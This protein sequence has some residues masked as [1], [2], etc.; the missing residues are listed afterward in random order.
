M[1]LDVP[2]ATTDGAC[3]CAAFA[4]VNFPLVRSHISNSLRAV[5]TNMP[6][7]RQIR[8][9]SRLDGYSLIS[10]ALRKLGA[11]LFALGL[12]ACL[13]GPL[14]AEPNDGHGLITSSK[15]L[16]SI[17]DVRIVDIAPAANGTAVLVLQDREQRLS[18][19]IS[20]SA[21]GVGSRVPLQSAKKLIPY[22][23]HS[24]V[25]A[26]GSIWIGGTT[27]IGR[28]Y[29]S[30]PL[31]DAYLAKLGPDG[32][33]VWEIVT[34]RKREHAIFDMAVLSS[35][36]AVIVG[37]EDDTN[38]L[39]RIS[40][41]G[42]IIWEKTFGTGRGASVAVL[43]DLIAVMGSG[44]GF[45]AEGR[46][47][48]DRSNSGGT[49]ALPT[50]CSDS[51]RWWPDHLLH[52]CGRYEP[53]LSR[54][55]NSRSGARPSA[56]CNR[57]SVRWIVGAGLVHDVAFGVQHLAVRNWRQLLSNELEGS[58]RRSSGTTRKHRRD[59]ESRSAMR[60]CELDWG[61]RFPS[62]R[63]P[64]PYRRVFLSWTC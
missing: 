2:A 8:E 13:N 7:I 18:L 6:D 12:L 26:D 25:A 16:W 3:W 30:A 19:L 35:G 50:R 60:G 49:R 15:Y 62:L 31:S 21:L 64:R 54:P 47:G 14:S 38:W 32:H 27:N 22:D 4:V 41:D 5:G 56:K 29:A 37:R 23:I 36:D 11:L 46:S 57:A 48:D 20:A 17:P 40:G 1:T 39:A 45:V 61:T 24:A 10:Q 43:N 33:L 52:C 44:A 63:A 42:K 59:C 58:A 53:F 34:A 51:S 9:L 55:S 28:S